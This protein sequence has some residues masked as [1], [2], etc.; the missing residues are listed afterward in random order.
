MTE[1][2]VDLTGEASEKYNLRDLSTVAL[3]ESG[4]FWDLLLRYHKQ[5]C[6]LGCSNALKKA[7]EQRNEMAPEG[8]WNNH[9]Y[10][11]MDVRF[12][13]N[14][15]LIRLRNPWGEGEWKGTFAD[16]DE[17]WDKNRGLKEELNYEFGKDGTWWMNYED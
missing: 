16:E 3:I 4:E 11:I 13:R 14:N 17:E 1:A 9:A 15:K 6:L 2:L 5:G 12:T 8:I 7:E 10:G